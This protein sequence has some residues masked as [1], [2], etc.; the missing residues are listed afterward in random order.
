MIRVPPVMMAIFV[1][2]RV[3]E[4]PA[5]AWLLV[6]NIP[7]SLTLL[8]FA[9]FSAEP[10]SRE[11][12]ISNN[13]SSTATSSSPGASSAEIDVESGTTTVDSDTPSATTE[14]APVYGEGESEHLGAERSGAPNAESESPATLIWEGV[15]Y[16][17]ECHLHCYRDG[18]STVQATQHVLAYRGWNRLSHQTYGA[19]SMWHMKLLLF[20]VLSRRVLL[21]KWQ[22]W[23]PL[24]PPTCCV[25]MRCFFL[26]HHVH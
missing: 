22:P 18:S 24:F 13:P 26:P 11:R 9:A 2:V 6:T 20:S 14:S 7:V 3:G 16:R 8:H 25:E 23:G 17:C 1:R 19:I 15:T 5:D 12:I 10:N 4:H 21:S